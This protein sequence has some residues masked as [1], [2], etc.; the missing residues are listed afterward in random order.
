MRHKFLS[1]FINGFSKTCPACH[2]GPIFQSYLKIRDTC[3]GCGE[4]LG[5]YPCDDGPAYIVMCIISFI[6]VPIIILALL[7]WDIS[8][9]TTLAVSVPIMFGLTLWLLPIVK[10]IFLN[11]LWTLDKN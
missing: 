2:K 11:I 5:H 1:A 8:V 3:P 10:A 4:K 7:I 9:T 6:Y